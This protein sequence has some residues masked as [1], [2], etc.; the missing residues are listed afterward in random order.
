MTLGRNVYKHT[1][2]KYDRIYLSVNFE[3]KCDVS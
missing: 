2:L 1:F 3:I